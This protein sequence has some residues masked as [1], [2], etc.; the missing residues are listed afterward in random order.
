M[1]WMSASGMVLSPGGRRELRSHRLK[2][3][4]SELPEAGS[5]GGLPLRDGGERVGMGMRLGR[6]SSG[7]KP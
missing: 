5:P 3:E 2:K 6:C 1:A 7:E 4:P